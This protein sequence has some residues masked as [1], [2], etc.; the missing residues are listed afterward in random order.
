MYLLH[1]VVVGVKGSGEGREGVTSENATSIHT[2]NNTVFFK[3]KH[4]ERLVEIRFWG[5][6]SSCSGM[7]IQAKIK[8]SCHSMISD[9]C[10]GGSGEG[11][12]G[13]RLDPTR[14]TNMPFCFGMKY[15]REG[16]ERV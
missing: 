1:R 2:N 12:G 3:K 8:K 15:A 16:S 6:L 9:A 14:T 10:S 5:S 4:K 13:K 11:T 7:W